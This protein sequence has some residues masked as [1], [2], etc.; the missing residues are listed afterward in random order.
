MIEPTNGRVV[1][2]TPYQG[3]DS[4]PKIP[5]DPMT[6]YGKPLTALIVHVWTERLVN[7]VVFDADGRQHPRTSV[8]LLQDDDMPPGGQHAEWMPYQKGQAAKTEAVESRLAALGI[9][10]SAV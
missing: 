6:Y 2:F 7:L 4:A 8:P 9:E 5:A 1:L 3:N 10:G